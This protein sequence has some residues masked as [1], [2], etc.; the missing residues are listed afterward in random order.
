LAVA[1]DCV[2]TRQPW[3]EISISLAPVR[4]RAGSRI[5][6]MRRSAVL[7]TRRRSAERWAHW[8]GLFMTVGMRF[9]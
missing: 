1:L 2:S 5:E 7:D 8:T 3:V 6:H 9:D 4:L